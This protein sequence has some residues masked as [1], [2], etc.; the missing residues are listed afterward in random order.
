MVALLLILL[1][2]FL[3]VGFPL[4]VGL[5][6]APLIVAVGY[7]P[8][9]DISMVAQ[10]FYVGVSSQALMAVPMFILAAD[11]MGAGQTAKRLLELIDS[12]VG[13]FYGGLAI[14][15]EATCTV[16]GALSGSAMAT[17]V[18]IGKTMRPGLLQS[19][20]KDNHIIGMLVNA[21]NI[22][23][24]IPP[25]VVMIMYCVVS[26]T[27]VASM[28]MAGIV[29]GVMIFAFFAIYDY[30]YARRHKIPRKPKATW[31]QRGHALKRGIL[32]LGV[33][34]LILG[35]IYTGFASP[36]EAAALSVLYAL[37][38]EIVIYRSFSVK[39][40][41]KIAY[42]TASVSATVFI[43]I[44]AGQVF[45]WV[46]TYANLPALLT[47][48]IMGS[49][50]SAM[51]I[52]LVTSLFFFV[53]CM[54]VDCVPV[55]LILVPIIFPMAMAAGIDPVHLGIIATVQSCIGSV[56]PPFG[57]NIFTACVIF[58]KKFMEVVKGIWPYLIIFILFA[59]LVVIFPQISLCL[60]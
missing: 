49:Q 13:H 27:S 44:A 21:S 41:P 59:L 52:L 25:S 22:A 2:A 7:F 16:F 18:A 47:D 40:I 1:F 11:I 42:S 53:A 20:Y 19:G 10:Q 34:V 15:A 32:T 28:F 50:P 56:T 33:P 48:T 57:A 24:L 23:F 14:T 46:I 9:L 51:V 26:G 37:F 60:I 36:T 17:M 55:I 39:D 54:F 58:E 35:T 5:I 30:I 6:A 38:L 12:L 43:L 8:N 29:P 45:S 31:K 4:F 3:I